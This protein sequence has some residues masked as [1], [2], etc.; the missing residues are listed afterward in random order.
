MLK[1]I[2]ILLH[3]FMPFVTEEIYCALPNHLE[4]INIESWP[5]AVEIETGDLE[6]VDFMIEAIQAVREV[7]VSYDVKPSK[8]L[9]VSVLDANN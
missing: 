8:P 4:S 5:L 7:R 2:L 3:P 1:N 9:N 6:E